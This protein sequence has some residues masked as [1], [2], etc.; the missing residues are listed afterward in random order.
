[1]SS[2]VKHSGAWIRPELTENVHFFRAI[3]AVSK[4]EN[5]GTSRKNIQKMAAV[6][7]PGKTLPGNTTFQRFPVTK[8]T[9]ELSVFER[10]NKGNR[11]I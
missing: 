11:G 3:P 10:K 6:F 7:R 4:P 8:K 1:M 5:A 2:Q 9:E